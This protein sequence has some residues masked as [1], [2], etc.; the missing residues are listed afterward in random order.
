M[1]DGFIDF[2]MCDIDSL[3][4]YDGTSIDAIRF[5]FTKKNYAEQKDEVIRWIEVIKERG[6][7]STIPKL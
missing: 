5:G 1:A 2:G 6:Y 7:V 4:P 3:K